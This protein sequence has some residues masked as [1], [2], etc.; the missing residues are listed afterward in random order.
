MDL[1]S[2]IRGGISNHNHQKQVKMTSLIL[3]YISSR[4]KLIG[5]EI[6]RKA[7]LFLIF[8]TSCT[9][10]NTKAPSV[11]GVTSHI[12]EAYNGLSAVDGKAVLIE[13]WLKA[14]H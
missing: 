5:L 4:V 2:P 1:P 11:S 14:S 10:T 9:H 12:D 7:L 13:S 6:K 3:K 8:L